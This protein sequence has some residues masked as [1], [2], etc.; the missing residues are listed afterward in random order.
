MHTLAIALMS[1]FAWKPTL[2]AGRELAITRMQEAQTE[3]QI[4]VV[5]RRVEALQEADRRTAA[6]IM[7][8]LA[9]VS[10]ELLRSSDAVRNLRLR[11]DADLAIAQSVAALD[12]AAESS[13]QVAARA[14]GSIGA[15]A[16]TTGRTRTSELTSNVLLS[17]AE[18]RDFDVATSAEVTNSFMRL[19]GAARAM[20]EEG[21]AEQFESLGAE[22][23]EQ[24]ERRVRED[25]E[26]QQELRNRV[27][28]GAPSLE[29]AIP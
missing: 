7:D 27:T 12:M 23:Y 8:D 5:N 2:E 29:R 9:S 14:L 1:G 26:L 4:D 6:I 15:V 22:I 19:S 25:P 17:L 13:P 18:R 28:R 11:S 3:E 10:A 24:A 21:Q 20:R 16:L